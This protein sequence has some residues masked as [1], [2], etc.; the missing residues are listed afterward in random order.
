MIIRWKV[1][2][3]NTCQVHTN[4]CKPSCSRA[5]LFTYIRLKFTWCYLQ[6]PGLPLLF[7][8]TAIVGLNEWCILQFAQAPLSGGSMTHQEWTQT[9]YLLNSSLPTI[10]SLS[11]ASSFLNFPA[12]HALQIVSAVWNEVLLW[13]YAGILKVHTSFYL[14]YMFFCGQHSL[15]SVMLSFT[16]CI[17]SLTAPS[18]VSWEPKTTWS[19]L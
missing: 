17:T 7:C 8:I 16:S 14:L 10:W 3:T 9:L 4:T 1:C 19:G 6:K 12:K 15:D 13:V 18:L 11:H 5:T 2:H